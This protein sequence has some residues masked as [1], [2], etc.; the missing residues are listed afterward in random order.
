MRKFKEIT[1]T[2][3][4]IE[5]IQC[6][7]C[8]KKADRHDWSTGSYTVNETE[9]KILIRQRDGENYPEGGW[10]TEY[11]ADICP[12]CFKEKLIPWLNSQGCTAKRKEWDW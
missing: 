9:F 3:E 8:G 10:G 11:E 7:I 5:F 2:V 12:N 6:D 1:T 4:T